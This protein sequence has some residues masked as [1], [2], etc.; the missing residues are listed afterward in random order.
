MN[1]EMK[2]G[3]WLMFLGAILIILGLFIISTAGCSKNNET[4]KEIIKSFV[5]NCK[6]PV[7]SEVY[8]GTWEDRYIFKCDDIYLG[9]SE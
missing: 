8:F 4:K 2:K 5:K 3:L 7:S 9:V 6:S 1:S